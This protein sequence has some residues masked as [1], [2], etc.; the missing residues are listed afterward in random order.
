MAE[1]EAAIRPAFLWRSSDHAPEST[2]VD[3]V[4]GPPDCQGF[5]RVIGHFGGVVGFTLAGV[6]AWPIYM[7][8]PALAPTASA[9]AIPFPVAVRI[10]CAIL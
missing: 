1:S 8:P 6:A 3:L 4:E 7:H 9:T 10:A 5:T 2:L